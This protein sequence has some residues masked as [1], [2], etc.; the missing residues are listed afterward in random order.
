MSLPL[1]RL[2]PASLLALAACSTSHEEEQTNGFED[3]WD[4]LHGE[5]ADNGCSGVRVPDRG[6]FS[7]K[8]HLTFDDGP[9]PETTPKI[10]DILR[11][12]NA[13]ATFFIN[14]NRV[15]NQATRALVAEIVADPLFTLANHTYSHQNMATL[16]LDEARSQIDRVTATIEE[17]GGTPKFFRFPFGSSTCDTMDLI[18]ERN[19]VSTGWH[20]DSADWCF[21][22]GGGE[23]KKSTFKHVP[24]GFRHDMAG[25]VMSQ[26]RR[27]DGGIV[28]FH[29][30]HPNTANSLEAIL[31]TMEQSGYQY[32]ELDDVETFPL[33]N[34]VKQA[35][36]SDACQADADCNF[37]GGFCMPEPT[38]G[39]CTMEC[40]QTCPDRN[41]Y[42][43]T[44][45]VTPP[46]GVS[47][48]F[49]VCSLSCTPGSCR[50][51]LTCQAVT[52]ANG[53]ERNVC[54]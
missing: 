3:A 39:F 8:V 18:K 38:G 10:M 41:G 40:D 19:L 30:I 15:K 25:F 36:F 7:S 16:S 33:L 23:C 29:D 27:N 51:G 6:P 24:D 54:F 2:L 14:G 22:S 48:D 35:F 32:V 43:T 9:N 42:A 17:A 1:L 31:N 5:K 49:T 26:V 11:A 44:R 53:L 13:P 47:D 28:L 37:S 45:C 12:H 50:D 20:I 21:A 34:N 52:G 4:D 46:V